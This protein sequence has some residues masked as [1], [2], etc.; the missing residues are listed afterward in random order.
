MCFGNSN[1]ASNAATQ[2]SQQQ[3]Q[4]INANIGGINQAFAGRQQQYSDYLGALNKSYQTQLD[5]QQAQSSRSLKFSLARGGMTGSSVSADQGAELQREGGQGQ[6]TA[7]EQAQAKLAGL[8]S[9]DAATK[10][11]MISLATSGANVGNAAQQVD[12][13]LQA[14]LAG[15]QSALGPNTLG[16]AFGG[17]TNTVNA[18]NTAAA[19]RMGLR[20]AQSYTGAFSNTANTS[21]GFGGSGTGF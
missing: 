13:S 14:N 4:S 1:A 5:L 6:I 7:A 15:A 9:S 11:Q 8:Q 17:I 18:M 19:T 12:T 3:Q 16:N 20:A 2:Q 21:S 10:N